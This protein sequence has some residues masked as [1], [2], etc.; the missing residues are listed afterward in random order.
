MALDASA[1]LGSPEIAGVKVNPRGFGKA[2]MSRTSVGGVGAA[3]GISRVIV[4]AFTA[5]KAREERAEAAHSTAPTFRQ[6]AW[7]A[8]TE[9]DLA[10]VG[11][12]TRT[13][14]KLTG[15]LARIPREQVV[16]IDVGRSA[17]LIASPLT[18]TFSDGQQWIFEVPALA[19]RSARKLAASIRQ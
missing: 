10:L 15:I 16:S 9:R 3:A 6:L 17:P 4:Q 1:L 7:L 13:I 2:L 11:M 19:K 12:D 18:V 14:L 5:K 8:L